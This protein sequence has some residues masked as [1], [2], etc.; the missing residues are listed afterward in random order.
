MESLQCQGGS[1]ESTWNFGNFLNVP[2]LSTISGTPVFWGHPTAAWCL[3]LSAGKFGV[4]RFVGAFIPSEAKGTSKRDAQVEMER[5]GI[6]IPRLPLKVCRCADMLMLLFV[7]VWC[8]I[9]LDSL[10]S[11]MCFYF[12]VHFLHGC[13]RYRY[14]LII[15]ILYQSFW[16]SVF[17]SVSGNQL[18]DCCLPRQK[19]LPLQKL[20]AESQVANITWTWTSKC[21]QMFCSFFFF[22]IFWS[23]VA[24]AV[25]EVS[26]WKT[27][28]GITGSN[29]SATVKAPEPRR[30]NIDYC[31]AQLLSS[32]SINSST[33]QLGWPSNL[34]FWM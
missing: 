21:R 17:H 28:H 1:T 12:S 8:S 30:F 11:V 14:L 2:F 19:S 22:S 27:P 25:H 16:H 32:L 7:A 26:P 6:N 20:E 5:W 29:G 13:I 34:D 4:G 18:E 10:Y 23:R 3:I 33:V 31:E 15:S 24:V 9:Y